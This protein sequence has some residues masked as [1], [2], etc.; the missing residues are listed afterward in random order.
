MRALPLLC[1]ALAAGCFGG[2]SS[3]LFTLAAPPP[4]PADDGRTAAFGLGPITLP[5]YLQRTAVVT[6]TSPT[7]LTL[8][9][10]DAWAEPL[11]AGT[12]RVLTTTLQAQLAP[13]RIVGFPWNPGDAPALA[14]SVEIV[15]FERQPDGQVAL[16]ARWTLRRPGQ[17]V[18]GQ[19]ETNCRE[20]LPPKADTPTVVEAMSRCLG[21]LGT[22]IASAARPLMGRSR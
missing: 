9:D 22:D 18:L 1:L 17:G 2:T 14:A 7:E 3:R 19:Q 21:T 5:D 4:A 20:P 12:T 13:E 16:D 11:H 10:G 8:S 15:R 6:R